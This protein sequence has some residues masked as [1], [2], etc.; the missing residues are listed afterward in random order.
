MGNKLN[1]FS[2]AYTPDP[3]TSSIHAAE[4]HLYD[5]EKV[6]KSKDD[7]KPL[8]DMISAHNKNWG[9]NKITGK[10]RA[11][12]PGGF[13]VSAPMD[14]G[15]ARG[16]NIRDP[17]YVED[18]KH[19]DPEGYHE[20]F[21]DMGPIE[22][23]YDE[24][25]SEP[26]EE[27]N[28]Q[29]TRKD[30]RIDDYL[31]HILQDKRRGSMKKNPKVDNSRKPN[32]GFI[33]EI[34]NRDHQVD[35]E[36]VIEVL[37]KFAL[38][39]MPEHYPNLKSIGVALHDD[40]FTIHPKTQERIN[41]NPH[42]HFD[43]I[44]IAHRLTDEEKEDFEKWKKE[45]MEKEKAEC[46]AKGIKFSAEEFKN[47][48]W[49]FERAKR[50]GKAEMNGLSVQSSLSGACAEMGFRTQGINTAQIQME[51][52]IR[53]DLLD[54]AESYGIPVDRTIEEN[55]EKKVKIDIYKAREDAK[56]LN[57][58]T[59]EI[60]KQVK[61]DAARNQK[62]EA[63]L[64]KREKNVE[65]LEEK[66][67]L[68]DKKE[69][70]ILERE[71]LVQKREDKVA[72]Y[73]KRIDT[74]VQDEAAVKV[75]REEADKR[76]AEQDK[77]DETLDNREKVLDT[78]RDS[79]DKR[80][81]D[82]DEFE[83]SLDERKDDLDTREA[84]ITDREAAAKKVEDQNKTDAKTNEENAKI[85]ETNLKEITKKFEDFAPMEAKYKK[86][87]STVNMAE[88]I[89]ADVNGIG[90]QLKSELSNSEG[91]WWDK[92]EYA[93]SNFTE[94]CQKIV[95]K[96]QD[97]IQGF[98]NFLQGKTPQDFRKMADDME[99]NKAPTFEE[100]EQ[101]WNSNSLDWQVD[102]Q[103]NKLALKPVRKS[104]EVERD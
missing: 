67:K 89:K 71:K 96:C 92:V 57:K 10:P 56:V 17:K 55:P 90:T 99:R 54:F 3:I 13:K 52:A 75:Q 70:A 32:Y 24:I 82:L 2:A 16:H 78:K 93:V 65:G 102:E 66:K 51:R 68:L 101:K 4:K 58:E 94:R 69:D 14:T 12:T 19:I 64:E 85:N 27:Y 5:I 31:T 1:L 18:K 39:W 103:K 11:S 87:T 104:Y 79:L 91:S 50:Y 41:S 44:P 60:L 21:I 84:S 30:R 46:K 8:N 49:E 42:I 37:K 72:P 77:R 63:E 83:E 59:K 28:S 43:Y 61:K 22:K 35:H 26:L 40:E 34:G 73:E 20:T 88:Q 53:E 80:K 95:I 23:C 7:V 36:L 38:E 15:Y 98:K 48:D 86:Y 97:A 100:Y 76:D 45:L 9:T 25:F 29:Q 47:R 33:F 74:L 81:D 62:K 6:V